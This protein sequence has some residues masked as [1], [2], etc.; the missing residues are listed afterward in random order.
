VTI[1]Y[2]GYAWGPHDPAFGESAR[3]ARDVLAGKV[4]IGIPGTV[5][6]VD[7]RDVAAVHAAALRSGL[8]PRRYVAT[9]ERVTM[10]E[11]MRI[12]AEAEQ[13]GDLELQVRSTMPRSTSASHRAPFRRGA[14]ARRS[15]SAYARERPP[16][17]RLSRDRARQDPGAGG[18]RVER[19]GLTCDP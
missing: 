3:L 17:R 15:W 8:G 5:P 6:V 11:L 10:V 16:V 19:V 13:A 7:V 9:S 18:L 4:S 12:V 1:T 2:P 14:L